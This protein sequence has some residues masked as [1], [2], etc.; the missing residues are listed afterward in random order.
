ML[1]IIS[2]IAAWSFIKFIVCENSAFIILNYDDFMPSRIPK[3]KFKQ[4]IIYLISAITSA[5]VFVIANYMF[6]NFLS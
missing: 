1:V 2:I 5:G 6:I 4:N 3:R